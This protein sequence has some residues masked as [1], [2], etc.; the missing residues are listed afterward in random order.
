MLFGEVHALRWPVALLSR[1]SQIHFSI[2]SPGCPGILELIQ[3]CPGVL[4]IWHTRSR[5]WLKASQGYACHS[6]QITLDGC[7]VFVD[8][9]I[10]CLMRRFRRIS[11]RE[12]EFL[13]ISGGYLLRYLPP[14]STSSEL[15]VV[16]AR[17]LGFFL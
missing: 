12:R 4:P 14:D 9:E 13:G 8:C 7:R 16:E 6:E 2:Y 11:R 5:A 3:K 15:G 10:G 1:I 17:G